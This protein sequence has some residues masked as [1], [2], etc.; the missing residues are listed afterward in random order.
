[1][2]VTRWGGSR[3]GEGLEGAKLVTDGRQAGG[4]GSVSASGIVM[5]PPVEFN[6]F[7]SRIA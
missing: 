4:V 3:S 7:S 5:G 2:V 1:M 6:H